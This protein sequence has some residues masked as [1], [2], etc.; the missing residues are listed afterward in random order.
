MK[1]KKAFTL[2]ELLVVIV[3]IAVLASIIFVSLNNAR[4]KA[5]ETK[6]RAE[7]SQLKRYIEMKELTS[8]P[9]Q[10]SLMLDDLKEEHNYIL[11][12]KYSETN[13]S[14][15]FDYLIRGDSWCTDQDNTSILGSCHIDG[16]DEGR[17][18]EFIQSYSL[19]IGITG[20]GNVTLNGGDPVGADSYSYAE[21]TE[22]TVVAVPDSG[23]ELTG[24]SGACSG[25]GAC[26][27]TMN[28]NKTV[29]A[30]F[31]RT[32][33]SS[34]GGGKVASIESTYIL[35]A[36]STDI[37]T[38]AQWG[39]QGTTTGATSTTDGPTNTTTIVNTCSTAGIAARLCN[40]H[41]SG[42]YSDWYLPA[43]DELHHKLYPNRVAIGG[44]NTDSGY[45]SSTE[46]DSGNAWAVNFYPGNE[47]VNS[48]FSSNLVR[49]VRRHT[50]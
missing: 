46:Y 30:N 50:E 6:I 28:S 13:Q 17:C 39:C 23:Y 32:I 20:S 35:I 29:T 24:W 21:N 45:W 34:F 10:M 38:G 16:D 25:T 8:T 2:I 7:A 1:H 27:V 26:S 33:G 43:R 22:V 47:C 4:N 14:F 11:N 19:T 15:C 49:C 31:A 9:E 5:E 18:A 3:A 48:K 42:G 41:V 40:D 12:S 44:F 37:S 36:A